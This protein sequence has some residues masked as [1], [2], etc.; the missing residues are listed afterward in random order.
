MRWKT[1]ISGLEPLTVSTRG[2]EQTLSHTKTKVSTSTKLA[3]RKVRGGRVRGMLVLAHMNTAKWQRMDSQQ[4]HKAVQCPCGCEI[5]N[6]QHVLSGTCEYME[7]WLDD[8]YIAVSEILQS[9]GESVQQRWLMAQNMEESVAAVVNMDVRA[10][11]PDALWELGLSVKTLIGKV[12]ARLC[13]VNKACESWPMSCEMWAP[14][15]VGPQVEAMPA[16]ECV[17]PSADVLP[18]AAG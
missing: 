12:E 14:E 2:L 13:A 5:Q 16:I 10:V 1:G 7:E 15:I 17:P 4:R 11:T 3:A 6:V 18:E 9:E 8:M